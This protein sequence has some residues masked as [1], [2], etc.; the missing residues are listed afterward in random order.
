MRLDISILQVYQGP[1]LFVQPTQC[2]TIPL[3]LD[4]QKLQKISLLDSRAFAYFLDEDFSK[5]HKKNLLQKSKT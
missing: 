4:S 2:F 1:S 3:F 5:F